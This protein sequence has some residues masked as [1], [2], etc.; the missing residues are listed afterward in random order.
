MSYFISRVHAD[1]RGARP[2]RRGATMPP[3]SVPR[4][5]HKE[6]PRMPRIMLPTPAPLT[7]PL[8]EALSRRASFFGAR[9]GDAFSEAELGTILGNALGMRDE[10]VR[11][12]PSGGALYPIETYL[13]GTVLDGYPSG[14]FHYHPKAHALEHLWDTP[15]NFKMSDVIHS[16]V[17]PLSQTLIL[18]TAVWGRSSAKYG[19]WAYNLALLEAGHMGQNILLAMTASGMQARPAGGFGDEYIA[20]LL[21]LDEYEQPV[22]SILLSSKKGSAP[23][24]EKVFE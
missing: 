1:L 17:T 22:H 6:Y 18:F 7:M 12:Y 8:D 9:A 2:I 5:T 10:F 24:I 15:L 13:L 14:V 23:S 3:H 4:G 16:T 20:K 19:D 11:K 21:D